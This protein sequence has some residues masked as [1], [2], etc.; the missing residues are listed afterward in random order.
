MGRKAAY[1]VQ[2]AGV[3]GGKEGKKVE[4]QRKCGLV[5]HGKCWGTYG[6]EGDPQKDTWLC[7]ECIEKD[8]EKLE[9]NNM[10]SPI[11]MSAAEGAIYELVGCLVETV[12][13][14]QGSVHE[15]Q[16]E[17]RELKAQVI[18]NNTGKPII[19]SP[20]A[21]AKSPLKLA[22]PAVHA[23]QSPGNPGSQST[24]GNTAP[25][26]EAS[27]TMITA[28]KITP[29]AKETT[30]PQKQQKNDEN[31]DRKETSDL[32]VKTKTSLENNKKNNK[33]ALETVKKHLPTETVK[34]HIED[35]SGLP[36]T[37]AVVR[38]KCTTKEGSKIVAAAL[39]KAIGEEYN[40]EQSRPKM[41][42]TKMKVLDVKD[43]DL[44]TGPDGS[45]DRA[46]LLSDINERN[47][48]PH[49]GFL[50]ILQARKGKK[51]ASPAQIILL[52]DEKTKVELKKGIKIGYCRLRVMDLGCLRV[53]YKCGGYNHSIWQ[54][55]QKEPTC[56]IC[57]AQGHLG[58]DCDKLRE[59]TEHKC[60][61]CVNYN[62]RERQE[63]GTEDVILPVE[64]NHKAGD[65]Q[66]C[67]VYKRL[68]EGLKLRFK[69][70]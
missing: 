3:F 26:A 1:C 45:V 21:V 6:S 51:G 33:Q 2:C 37:A 15:L 59:R 36:G 30:P 43:E 24:N 56:Y 34:D 50:Q 67:S 60:T 57:A 10:E 5:I 32:F 8:S 35:V 29:G 58:R 40:I 66:K 65:I 17:V 52:V 53:C 68:E 9:E 25:P 19:N 54:C 18:A 69:K 49:D 55:H 63:V 46:K 7:K 20:V 4:C 16:Q 28:E 11:I 42:K 47:N 14:L 12:G 39:E 44:P 61:N 27:P 70:E 22:R 62:N 38:I 13:T 48:L 64:T 41:L 23:Q 31:T